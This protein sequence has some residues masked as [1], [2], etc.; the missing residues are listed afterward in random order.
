MR[1]RGRSGDDLEPG[2]DRGT[3]GREDDVDAVALG[4]DLGAVVGGDD[5]PDERPIGRE[6]LGRGLV[7]V[8]SMNA[9]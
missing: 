7:A 6:E 8:R 5:R 3:G 1:R 9:V 4:P 2:L